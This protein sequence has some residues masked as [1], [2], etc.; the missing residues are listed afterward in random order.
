MPS[1]HSAS[2][3]AMEGYAVPTEPHLT[4]AQLIECLHAAMNRHDLATFVECFA[5]DYQS[6]QPVHPDRAFYGQEQVRRNWAAIFSQTPDFRATLLA[7]TIAGDTIWAEWHWTG[8]RRDGS[9]LELRGVTLFG[10][11]G[12]RISHGRLYMEPVYATGD[13]IEAAMREIVRGE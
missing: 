9:Q 8:I 2:I 1:R 4:P 10:V 11:R 6:E 3:Q 12:G 7:H 13:G 5:A